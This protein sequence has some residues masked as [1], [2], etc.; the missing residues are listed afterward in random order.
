MPI[1]S[2]EPWIS[3]YRS[4]RSSCDNTSLFGEGKE[5]DNL[6]AVD[7]PRRYAPP[8]WNGGV[9]AGAPLGRGWESL[10]LPR[11][12]EAQHHARDVVEPGAPVLV[13]HQVAIEKA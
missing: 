1:G 3:Y 13:R 8:S 10:R 12:D 4:F 2:P 5:R 7:R 9:I 6:D 11:A